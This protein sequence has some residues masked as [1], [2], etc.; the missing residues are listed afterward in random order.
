MY[1]NIF[2]D[3]EIDGRR[4]KKIIT[5]SN[6]DLQ[7]EVIREVQEIKR[8]GPERDRPVPSRYDDERRDAGRDRY[9]EQLQ[10]ADLYRFGY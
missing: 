2:L 8:P 1:S 4:M 6:S 7:E 10:R 5:E 3:L 9:F